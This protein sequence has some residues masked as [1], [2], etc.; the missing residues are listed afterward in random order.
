MNKR[1]K[2]KR[3]REPAR[4]VNKFHLLV[5]KGSKKYCSARCIILMLAKSQDHMIKQNLGQTQRTV[6]I[7]IMP[8]K[9]RRRSMRV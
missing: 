4:P 2:K 7:L 3:R 5:S 9:K 1:K 8:K 6:L